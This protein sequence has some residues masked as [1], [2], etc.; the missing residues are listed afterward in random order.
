M[1]STTIPP[2]KKN[3]APELWCGA[4]EDEDDDDDDG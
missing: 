3:K 2:R 4:E 1:I